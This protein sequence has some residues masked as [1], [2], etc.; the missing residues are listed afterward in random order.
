MDRENES[1]AREPLRPRDDADDRNESLDARFSQLLA[2]S[3]PGVAYLFDAD[4]ALLW[5]N[6]NLE[7]VTGYTSRE[8]AGASLV[9]FVPPDE[10][11]LV[12]E[13]MRQVMEAGKASV[14]AN[15]V[16]LDGHATPHLFSGHRV[17]FAG[18]PCLIGMGLDLT[19]LKRTEQGLRQSEARKA[20]ILE[21]A[22]DCIIAIDHE[23]WILEFN[24]AAE[25]CFG[26]RREDAIGRRMSE[27]IVP[28]AFRETHAQ[29]MRRYL[30]TGQGRV[31]GRRI[32][33][34]AMRSDASVFPAEISIVPTILDGRPI[35]TAYLRDVTE[36][37]RAEHALRESEHRFR[38]IFEQSPLPMLIY[39]PD[40]SVRQG[41][42]ASERLYGI[43]VADMN[44]LGYRLFE[45]AQV[46]DGGAMSAV[47]RA[48][49]G[50]TT[51]A[52]P[53]YY[54]SMARFP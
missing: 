34:P 27:L 18:A 19:E 11:L 36:R 15:L 6:R 53:I 12:V 46:I 29:G 2:D 49:G 14:E 39:A 4:G 10:R 21:A 41:N 44:R 42:H 40:G 26:Y 43:T 9:S 20:A 7:R 25:Q 50:E 1:P 35:F 16:A 37:R 8:L 54:Q 13:R 47:E 28:P 52:P 32:E 5:W 3:L 17:E 23:E 38:A 31:L 33:M 48:F 22:L 45:D 51:W 30:A 24:P